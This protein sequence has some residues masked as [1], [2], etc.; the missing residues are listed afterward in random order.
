MPRAKTALLEKT[1]ID[2]FTHSVKARI[3]FNA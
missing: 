3:P 2:Y 1:D